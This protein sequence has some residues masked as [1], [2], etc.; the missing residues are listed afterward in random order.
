MYPYTYVSDEGKFGDAILPEKSLFFSDL[1]QENISNEDYAHAKQVWDSFHLRNL[2]IYHD[3]Y[4]KT[5]VLFLADVFKNFHQLCLQTY[6]LETH[7]IF[8]LGL[9]W[10]SMIATTRVKLELLTD[11]DQLLFLENSI[12]GAISMITHQ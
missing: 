7:Y 12:H 6:R 5:D 1:K 9:L 11:P 4:L 8:T 10:D 3:L 2:G